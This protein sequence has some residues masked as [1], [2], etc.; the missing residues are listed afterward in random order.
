MKKWTHVVVDIAVVREGLAMLPVDD[1][2]EKLLT[3]ESRVGAWSACV[4]HQIPSDAP[5]PTE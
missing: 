4:W 3:Q 5:D 1:I 2:Q